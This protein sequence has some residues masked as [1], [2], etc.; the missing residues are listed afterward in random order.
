MNKLRFEHIDLEK[1]Q[2]LLD[3]YY[4]HPNTPKANRSDEMLKVHL[5]DGLNGFC[6]FA[7][8]EDEIVGVYSGYV[9]HLGDQEVIKMCHRHHIRTDYTKYHAY[10]MEENLERMAYEWVTKVGL[11]TT[12]VICTINEGNERALYGLSRIHFM[13]KNHAEQ[14]NEWGQKFIRTPHIWMPYL[15]KEQGVWQY[16]TWISTEGIPWNPDWKPEKK[17]IAPEVIEKMNRRFPRHK[18]T[19]GWYY[20]VED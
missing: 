5:Y 2:P 17:E 3:K 16:I 15:V 11:E 9:M 6:V 1:H 19:G 13:K 14:F 7:I 4:Q 8:A 20:I 18:E 12:P 10:I